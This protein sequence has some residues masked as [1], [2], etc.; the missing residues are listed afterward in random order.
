M[1]TVESSEYCA[2]TSQN[3]KKT[4]I[5]ILYLGLK[6]VHGESSEYYAC[7]VESEKQQLKYF[8]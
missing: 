6:F 4:A 8:I 5:K 7:T 2:C 3:W 1:Y